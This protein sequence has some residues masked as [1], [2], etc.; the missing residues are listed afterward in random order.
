M[1]LRSCKLVAMIT[2]REVLE[3]IEQMA[4]V[5]FSYICAHFQAS[6]SRMS[7]PIYRMRERQLIKRVVPKDEGPLWILTASGARRLE[8]YEQREKERGRSGQRSPS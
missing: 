4:P 6:P 5:P 1:T 2:Q 7:R 8:Y 3:Y